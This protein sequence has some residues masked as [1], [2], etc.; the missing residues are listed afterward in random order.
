MS[1]L[2][3]AKTI[4]VPTSEQKGVFFDLIKKNAPP[5]VLAASEEL[6]RELYNSLMASHRTRNAASVLM[7]KLQSPEQFCAP[8]L[9]KAMSDKLSSPLDVTGVVFQ[10]VRSTSSLLGLRK[11]L[12]L[13]INR[14]LLA[15]ACENF[16]SSETE[17]DN[18]SD[19]SLDRKSVV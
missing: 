4:T 2:P 3:A 16:E 18:Y 6:R 11:K 8:L 14:D 7:T 1:T 9:A 13:P 12:V 5:W 19:T 15:A 17:A 10:H